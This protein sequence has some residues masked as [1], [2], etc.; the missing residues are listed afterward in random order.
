MDLFLPENKDFFHSQV[1]SFDTQLAKAKVKQTANESSP[2][3]DTIIGA[4]IRP[5]SDTE[6][7]DGHISCVY[8]H[9][10]GG[11]FADIHAMRRKV[12]GR[13]AITVCESSLLFSF[14]PTYVTS[15]DFELSIRSNLWTSQ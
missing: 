7:E 10:E 9:C 11:G 6:K 4:R 3:S 1:A 15:T 2:D 14:A 12:N 8:A 5:L 13:P